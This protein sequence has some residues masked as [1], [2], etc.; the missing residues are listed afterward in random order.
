MLQLR[1]AGLATARKGLDS[2]PLV[3]NA[4]TSFELTEVVTL[5]GTS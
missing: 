1:S 4:I 3:A 2:L 5:D